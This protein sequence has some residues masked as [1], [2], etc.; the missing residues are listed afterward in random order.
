MWNKLG[1]N[2]KTIE[3][4][5]L[6]KGKKKTQSFIK[7]D[8]IGNLDYFMH[9]NLNHTYLINMRLIILIVHV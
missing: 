9:S 7:Q 2:V 5:E 6:I 4:N 3:N 8:K 1:E